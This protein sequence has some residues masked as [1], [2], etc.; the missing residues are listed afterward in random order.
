MLYLL[1]LEKYKFRK[2]VNLRDV[3]C[4][5]LYIFLKCSRKFKKKK[6]LTAWD[7]AAFFGTAIF[8]PESDLRWLARLYKK[9]QIRSK[10]I[11]IQK[12]VSRTENNVKTVGGKFSHFANKITKGSEPD[13]N[14]TYSYAYLWV[15]SYGVKLTC[16]QVRNYY[17]FLIKLK[18]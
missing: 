15:V 12:Q 9:E 7:F 11:K 5:I 14:L 3:K 1:F 10:W 16:L 18:H 2:K 13:C 8:L 17:Y 6:L 4:T